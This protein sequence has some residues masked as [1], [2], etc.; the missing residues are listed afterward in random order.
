M[1]KKLITGMLLLSMC[2]QATAGEEAE[3]ILDN[4]WL[5]QG[6]I[7]SSFQV[8]DES[9][10]RLEIMALNANLK[11]IFK[12]NLQ[13][14]GEGMFVSMTPAGTYF[15]ITM[16]DGRDKPMTP[17]EEAEYRQTQVYH[18][19]RDVYGVS[20]TLRNLNWKITLEIYNWQN[21]RRFTQNIFLN[22]CPPLVGNK[23]VAERKVDDFQ[24]LFPAQISE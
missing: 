9:K 16:P 22:E 2:A 11:R 21:V 4:Y 15:K 10:F 14:T 5:E 3:D 18:Y 7:N 8:I 19:C 6:V 20:Q 12:D 23:Q 13:K 24:P 17:A 1:R